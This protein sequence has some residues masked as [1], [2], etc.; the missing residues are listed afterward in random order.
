MSIT[1]TATN[2]GWSEA[3]D[4]SFGSVASGLT[5]SGSVALL[6]SGGSSA[7]M[8]LG[9]S[10]GTAGAK[11]GSVTINFI[12]DG[13]GS[14]GLGTTILGSQTISVTGNVYSGQGVW[15]T[16]GGG[17]WTDFS[18][19]TTLGGVPGI[20][21][22]LSAGDTALFG[23]ALST[24][25]AAIS[26]SGASPHVSSLT[27]NSTASYTISQGTGG[28]I[29]NLDAGAGTASVI[30]T[31]GNHAITAPITLNSFTSFAPA[32]GSSLTISGAIGQSGSNQGLS[33]GNSGL[34]L[35]SGSNSYGGPTLIAAGVL[36]AGAANA[37]SANSAV[38]INGG[39]LDTSGFA[40]TVASLNIASS[41]CLNLG[42]GNTFASSGSAVLNGTLNISGTGT[43]GKYALLTYASESGSFASTAGLG[44]NYGLL[45][46]TTELDALHKAQVGAFTVTAVYPTVITG[47]TT[48]LTVN[49]ANSA[50][51][52][53]DIL[54]LTSSASGTGYGLGAAGSLAAT[55]SGNFTIA[56]GFNSTSL[57]SGSYTGTVTVTGTNNALG[58]P[59]LG[60][61]AT[62]TVT[63]NVLGHA[64]PVLSAAS[65]NNQSVF[66]GA[67]GVTASFSLTD[68][69]T[70]LSSL[71]VNT[72][73]SGLSGTTGTAV[74]AAGATCPYTA[75]L[76]AGTAGLSQSQ[77]FSLRAGDE[78]V[79]PGANALGTLTQSVTGLNVYNHA[80]GALSG[81]TLTIPT[82]IVGYPSSVSS[83]T[84]TVSNTAA[85][86]GGALQTTGS[87]SLGN[88]T[89]NNVN[90]VAA[91]GGTGSLSAT[92]AT[93]RA[94]GAFAQSNLTLTYAD[95]ST[96]SGALSNVGTTVVT[97][98]GNVLGHSNPLFAV[99]NGNNQTVITGGA[100][101]ASLSLT[102][103][104]TNLSP[105]D[106]NSLV[107]LTGAS[108]TAV[109]ASGGTA[110]YIAALNTGSVGLA[111]TDTVSL[112]AGD[113][114]ALPGHAALGT[115]SQ[116][117]IFNVL[118]HSNPALSIVGGNNQTVV[119]GATSIAASLN[120][121]NA[122]SNRAAFGREQPGGPDRVQRH[123]RGGLGRHGGLHRRLE[124]RQRRPGPDRHGQPQCGRSAG[125]AGTRLARHVE[126]ERDPQRLRPCRRLGQRHD[127]RVAVGPRRLRRIAGRNHVGHRY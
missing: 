57:L 80:A 106:V 72:L 60:S 12:S 31:S 94:I 92:L 108:G 56:S 79:L 48:A 98:T 69:G 81:G 62:Q 30:V 67:T 119:V 19:W 66:I 121:S 97:I 124:H 65:G 15:N 32:A 26:L 28:G 1:N 123:G 20:D 77:S 29:L 41:G 3:L 127:H 16:N 125:P 52:Q 22:T 90:N 84:L 47:G 54:N 73:S 34:L 76:N 109:V 45:Y 44:S 7:A 88:V 70:G 46:K 39:T 68:S 55:N 111:Q 61:G 114:Q 120:L 113:Q 101:S 95:A 116:N 42:L 14:S 21:G 85:S 43:L 103:S 8:S 83:N 36:S 117:V 99:A 5:S 100:A 17:S 51:S 37:L 86:P 27:F 74:I 122:G 58:G 6:A 33:L 9:M 107:G 10:T 115:L 87:T 63:V 49:V 82:V 104:G 35:L 11:G 105:L 23:S 110:G 71:D 75:T 96:Y 50:P 64:N 24:G 53:S 4:A 40:N 89:L 78:Q 2:D 18:K 118:D 112:N 102:D 25:S 93:G 59:A 38:T 126:P 13:A 91:S